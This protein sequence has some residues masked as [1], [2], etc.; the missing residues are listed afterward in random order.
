LALRGF[1]DDNVNSAPKNSGFVT[2]TLGYDVTPSVKLGWTLPQTTFLIGY[3]YTLKYYENTPAGST[4]KIDQNHLFNASL[5]HRF[6][7]RLSTTISDSFVIGQ[8]P[9]TLRAGNAFD[10]YQ[11]ISGNNIRNFGSVVVKGQVSST[12][13]ATIG[14]DNAF[15]DYADEMNAATLNRIDQNIPVEGLIQLAPETRMIVGYRFRA[16]NYN[17]G[18]YIDTLSNTGSVPSDARN[19][20]THTGYLGLD[21][22]FRPDLTGSFRAGAQYADYYND[23]NTQNNGVT[24]YVQA[25]L[26]YNYSQDSWAELGVTYDLTSTDLVG[27]DG[28]SFTTDAQTLVVYGSLKHRIASKVYGG[29]IAQFQDSTY[30]GGSFDNSTD[31]YFLVGLNLEYRFNQYLS[32]TAGYNFDRLDSDT[33]RSFSRNRVYIGIAATY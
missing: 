30:Q 11:R 7:E 29:L 22:N 26:R 17:S 4:S 10:S 28:S 23:P 16:I 12:F 8:E 19:A 20:Y 1:Y 9:D 5:D 21:H 33:N 6:S 2:E 24:P 15:F 14:Y 18:L 25:S 32:A 27:Y 31:L 3:A 13:S